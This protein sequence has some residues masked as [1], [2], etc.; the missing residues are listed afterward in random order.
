M[1]TR[2]AIN[3]FGRIGRLTFRHFMENLGGA[4]E[5]VALNDIG[6][7]DNLAYLLRHDS[8]QSNP[9]DLVIEARDNMLVWGDHKIR[10]TQ[11]KDPA[12]LPWQEAEVDLVIEASGQFTKKEDAEKH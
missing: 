12:D 1:A 3:G 4:V 11:I 5:V 10:F 9:E 2:V 6:E 7:L 8:I